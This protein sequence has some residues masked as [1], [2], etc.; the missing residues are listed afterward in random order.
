MPKS[1]P[2]W[3][4][5]THIWIRILSGDPA[6][7]IPAFRKKLERQAA[8]GNLLLAAISLWE[9]AMLVAKGRLKLNRDLEG[10]MAEAVMMPGLSLVPLDAAIAVES[11]FLPGS[12]HGDPADRQIVATARRRN[13]CLVTLDR[14]IL[15]Y[16]GEGWLL[17]REPAALA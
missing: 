14:E 1:E 7:D 12:F 17:G 11:C 5:D 3:V 15:A 8:A 6:L 2:A 16:A 4:L 13:A 10:W 9:C